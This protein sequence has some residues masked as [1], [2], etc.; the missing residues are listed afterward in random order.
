M[1]RNR[2]TIRGVR[3]TK[4]KDFTGVH[5]QI[6]LRLI[7]EN[8]Q[9]YLDELQDAMLV[10]TGKVWHTATIWRKLHK[11]GFSLQFAVF[12]AKQQ[13]Q[14]EVDAYGIRLLERVQHP[15]Q[16]IYIDETAR[17]ANASR[18]R[19][20]W[21]P[22]GTSPVIDAPFER[23]FDKR[24][25]LI[26]ACNWNGFVR[27]ACQVVEREKGKEDMNPERGTVDTERFE[28]YVEHHLVPV[29]GN[30]ARAEPNS[31]VVMDNAS[32]HNSGKIRRMIEGAG[33]LLVY[34]APYSPEYNPIEYYFGEYKKSLKR[35]SYR[36]GYEWFKVHQEALQAVT[37][38]MAKQFYRHC[39]VPMVAKWLREQKMKVEKDTD[40][41]PFPFNDIYDEIM[42]VLL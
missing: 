7:R 26:A 5:E 19:R 3:T 1:S 38:D 4:A 16:L 11:L 8:P 14:V 33:A 24:F 39:E 37:P 34:T 6:L 28:R 25:T 41:Y 31:I 23:D 20:A 30:S 22:K 40:R 27:G 9:L 2:R 42:D 21:A 35:N 36:M 13:S 32:I 18:R 12:R 10:E 15:R 17:G 29:L